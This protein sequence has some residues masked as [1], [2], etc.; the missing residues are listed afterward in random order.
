MNKYRYY[1]Y[2]SLTEKFD[3]LYQD[4]YQGKLKSIFIVRYADDF[5]I[6][7]H[8]Y[9][10]AVKIFEAVKKWLK[11]RLNL[12]VNQDKS[13][14]V[15]LTK[16]YSEFLG[17]KIKAIKR[18]NNYVVKSHIKDKSK[19][20]IIKNIRAKIKQIKKTPKP[21]KIVSLNSYILGQ[22]SY[23]NSATMV[24]KDFHDAKRYIEDRSVE[25]N[26]NRISRASMSGFKCEVTGIEL[27][28]R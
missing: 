12:D 5:K 2:Y 13:K 22:H 19:A 28:N 4:A 14:I 23:Y 9:E 11:E 15:N 17:I 1:D 21:N 20:R 3:N 16:D 8:K 6:L 25:Y 10:H 27:E 18:K 24:N 26:D 7:C